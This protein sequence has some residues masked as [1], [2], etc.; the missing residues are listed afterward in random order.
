MNIEV[1]TKYIVM[2]KKEIYA[3]FYI[4]YQCADSRFVNVSLDLRT[5]PFQ[6]D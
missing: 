3:P 6:M 2:M 1:T 5:K 4:A